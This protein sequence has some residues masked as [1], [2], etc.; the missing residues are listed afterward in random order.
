MKKRFWAVLLTT[1]LLFNSI[2]TGFVA[3]ADGSS[4]WA[5]IDSIVVKNGDTE[6]T[7]G[8]AVSFSD[9]LSVSYIFKDNLVV[10]SNPDDYDDNYIVLQPGETYQLPAMDVSDLDLK[11]SLTSRVDLDNDGTPLHIGD[12]A[13]D[14]DGNVTFELEPDIADDTEITIEDFVVSFSLNEEEIG[15][16]T[17]YTLNIGGRTYTFSISDNSPEAPSITTEGE[18]PEGTEKVTW[19]TTITNAANPVDYSET[20]YTFVGV[21]DSN[22]V[23]DEESFAVTVDGTSLTIGSERLSVTTD[24]DGN[25]KIAYTLNPDEVVSA[26]GKETIVTYS[27]DVDFLGNGGAAKATASRTVTNDVSLAESA[28]ADESI[29]SADGSATVS[30]TKN[31]AGLTKAINNANGKFTKNDSDQGVGEWTITVNT[32][33]Y[34][35]RNLTIYDYMVLGENTNAYEFT[36]DTSSVAVTKN[37]TELESTAYSL[38]TEPGDGYTWYVKFDSAAAGDVFVITYRTLLS[39]YSDY[40]RTNHSKA[41]YNTAFMTYEYE[42]GNGNWVPV[43]GPTINATSKI[44][45]N[46]GISVSRG[47]SSEFDPATH[48]I[49]WTVTVNQET[50]ALTGVSILD[51]IPA[52]QTFVST[53]IEKAVSGA[54]FTEDGNKITFNLGDAADGQKVSFKVVTQLTDD[55]V[56]I[57]SKNTSKTYSN[58]FRLYA[59]QLS[60]DGISCDGDCKYVSKVIEL[61][62]GDYDYA[63]HEIEYTVEVNENQMHMADI[64]VK[65]DLGAAGLELVEGSV[66]L[67][68]TALSSDAASGPGFTY[69]DG[70]L[71]VHADNVTDGEVGTADAK[72]VIT[73]TAKV[74]DSTLLDTTVKSKPVNIENTADLYTDAYDENTV[75]ESY[76]ASTDFTNTV[77]LK[78][79]SI[80][81]D[82]L[83]AD[84]VVTFNANQL[85]LPTNLLITDT[86]GASMDLD[87]SSVKVFIGTVDP[88]TGEISN[89]GTE[90]SEYRV[91]TEI[92]AEG[93]TVLTIRLAE[94]EGNTNAYY[95][96]YSATA[97][98]P[99]ANDF[100]NTVSISGYTE[101]VISDVNVAAKVLASVGGKAS[102]LAKIIITNVDRDDHDVVLPGST[103]VIR[104]EDG[105]VVKTVVTKADGTAKAVGG[106]VKNDTTYVVTQLSVKDGY[107][108]ESD[109]FEV[110]VSDN[111]AAYTF[112]NAKPSNDTPSNGGNGSN[113]SNGEPDINNGGSNNSDPGSNNSEP[114]HKKNGSGSKH[115]KKSKVT[116]EPAKPATDTEVT[117]ITNASESTE[118]SKAAEPET[119]HADSPATETVIENGTTENPENTSLPDSEIVGPEVADS[120]A[121]T[122]EINGTEETGEVKENTIKAAA[123]QGDHE[124]NAEKSNVKT[125]A[126]T[127]GFIG[128][129]MAYIAAVLS[130]IAG[131]FLTFGKKRAEY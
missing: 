51:T 26:S 76:S 78:S 110:T 44:T 40:L 112:E 87:V 27:A 69:S 13:I 50:Q 54:T 63:T 24:S 121:S 3:F 96:T 29:V 61:T 22:Q 45:T 106:K 15:T 89:S 90:E 72:A 11:G 107:V 117:E 6:L 34:A 120:A 66:K 41:P 21:L 58:S 42:K 95:I 37:G 64:A 108:L 113:N 74:P 49:T 75:T 99:G 83:T 103:F 80:D 30:T 12:I 125:L 4:D 8:D 10:S 126:Q 57:W 62:A 91:S 19:T 16:A 102:K 114:T 77:V 73:F 97:T 9:G 23:F 43:K 20:G 129:L 65:D 55:Q 46:A 130:I 86:L 48:R 119:T 53:D 70:K 109:P 104:D 98:D 116:E 111:A 36:L 33:D 101:K 52:D 14:T 128:T 39:N 47:L 84:Y 31:I 79:A 7:S 60:N 94:E 131:A 127:G 115:S 67:D 17:D 118:I 105:N 81:E 68:G 5:L 85:E 100:G 122:F 18:A 82:N 32:N 88:S 59:D 56:D 25:T 1:L 93:R 38:V 35:L 124:T 123:D 28:S 2:G 71:I 92:N